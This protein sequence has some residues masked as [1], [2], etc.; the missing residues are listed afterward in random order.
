MHDPDSG[1]SKCIE[2]VLTVLL[3]SDWLE[4]E[5]LRKLIHYGD[6]ETCPIGARIIIRRV[7][8]LWQYEGGPVPFE[9]P[10][11]KL[12]GVPVL[13][14]EATLE[15]KAGKLLVG[16][17]IIASSYFLLTRFEEITPRELRDP[18]GRFPG[19]ESLPY[20]AGFLDRPIVDEYGN[21]LRSWLKRIGVAL[22]DRPKEARKVYLTHDVDIPYR[23]HKFTPARRESVWRFK[24]PGNGPFMDPMLNFL[25]WKQNDPE[26]CFDWMIEQ[27]AK[28]QQAWGRDRVE[29]IYFILTG[30]TV[31]PDGNYSIKSRLIKRLIKKLIRS[32]AAI[33]LHT[34]YEAGQ[35]PEIIENEANRLREVCEEEITLNRHHYLSCREPEDFEYLLKAGIAHDFT[36]GYP[37]VAG[38][39]LGTSR[40]F[41]W[42]DPVQKRQTELTVHPM[43]VMEVSLN[44]KTYMGFNY[45]EAYA[46]TMH[47]IDQTRRCNGDLNLLWHNSNLTPDLAEAGG[48]HRNLYERILNALA[49]KE[50]GMERAEGGR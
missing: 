21:L 25:G 28:L 40:A 36:M 5:D 10:L 33:G 32:G 43:T 38:F 8:T 27:D 29:V 3:G 4:N 22:E 19:D 11:E 26:D 50:P 12:E 23:W 39:R 18:H 14:G 20:R 30:G 1:V 35:R 9:L 41:S 16:A 46:H 15:N 24:H 34:S 49:N 2:F 48:Y 17:D 6:A 13:F 31:L 7:D 44:L 37:D 47:L 45:E 42:F